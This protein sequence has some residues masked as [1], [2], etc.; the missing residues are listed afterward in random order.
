MPH[1]ILKLL[2]LD[3]KERRRAKEAEARAKIKC[4]WPP[5]ASHI[6]GALLS[7][8]LRLVLVPSLKI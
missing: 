6:S 7:E 5:C 3:N 8:F 1:L 4:G 2:K